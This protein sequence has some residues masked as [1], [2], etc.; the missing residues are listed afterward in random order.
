MDKRT[1]SNQDLNR[2][3]YDDDLYEDAH[4]YDLCSSPTYS[5]DSSLLSLNSTASK[6]SQLT[7]QLYSDDSNVNPV[8]Q[9]SVRL[10][11]MNSFENANPLIK[12]IVDINNLE[13]T[14]NLKEKKNPNE[15]KYKFKFKNIFYSK[16]NC[17]KEDDQEEIFSKIGQ[18]Y[19]QNLFEGNDLSYFAYGQTGAGKRYIELNCFLECFFFLNF[20]YFLFLNKLYD[21]G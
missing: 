1:Q 2:F 15:I 17:T 10:R 5:S 20:F 11:P 9:V 14:I 19:L 21:N 13:S 12:K 16:P 3:V 4:D 8:V 6:S 7:D 18:P